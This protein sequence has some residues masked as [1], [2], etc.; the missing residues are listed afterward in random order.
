[1]RD[2]NVIH[3]YYTINNGFNSI[4]MYYIILYL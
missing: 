1:M 3:V 4:L 2:L